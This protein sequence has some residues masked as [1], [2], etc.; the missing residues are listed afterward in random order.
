VPG[1]RFELFTGP[2]ASQAVLLER[3]DEFAELVLDFLTTYPRQ[4]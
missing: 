4:A 3:P 1:A 2:A